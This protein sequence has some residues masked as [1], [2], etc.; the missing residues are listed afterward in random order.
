MMELFHSSFACPGGNPANRLLQRP[1][2]DNQ[3]PPN[4]LQLQQSLAIRLRPGGCN[5]TAPASRYRTKNYKEGPLSGCCQE[6]HFPATYS[7]SSPFSLD[8]ATQKSASHKHGNRLRPQE[9]L[10]T[11]RSGPKRSTTINMERFC[12]RRTTPQAAREFTLTPCSDSIPPMERGHN[13][14]SVTRGQR[15]AP[16][17]QS[18]DPAIGI[19][20]TRSPGTRSVTT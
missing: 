14:G 13:S 3:P 11:I 16:A 12:S 15:C 6:I 7:C 19:P 4:S 8:S 2:Q 17:I 1:K 5:G 20:T 10:R 9:L 18:P